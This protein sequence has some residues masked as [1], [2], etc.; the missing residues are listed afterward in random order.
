[1]ALIIDIENEQG[2]INNYWKITNIEYI[3]RDSYKNAIDRTRIIISG[4][5]TKNARNNGKLSKDSIEYIANGL[6]KTMNNIY[7]YIKT[8]PE[9]IGATD[10]PGE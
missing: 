6:I 7:D 9:F 3:Y 2:Q 5:K 4:F 10:D 1:M 8:Q